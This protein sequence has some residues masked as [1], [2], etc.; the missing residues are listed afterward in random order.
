MKHI[1]LYEDFIN[2]AK[3]FM[4]YK[5]GDEFYYVPSTQG[6]TRFYRIL[7]ITKETIKLQNY[8][9]VRNGPDKKGDK[10]EMSAMI[11]KKNVEGKSIAKYSRGDL[12]DY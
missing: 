6:E 7:A 9:F 4:G 10:R 11:F 3:E 5:V 2:E 12:S 8:D 1:K